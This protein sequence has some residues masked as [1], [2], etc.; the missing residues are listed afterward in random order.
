[1]Y[2]IGLS[3]QTSSLC[4]HGCFWCGSFWC[5]VHC[6]NTAS[7]SPQGFGHS[8]Y[9]TKEA[10]KVVTYCELSKAGGGK[11]SEVGRNGG[12]RLDNATVSFV[13]V[14]KELL[15]SRLKYHL[16]AIWNS[17]Q[18]CGL[19]SG[20]LDTPSCLTISPFSL[21]RCSHFNWPYFQLWQW[22]WRG[23]HQQFGQCWHTE[24]LGGRC[25]WWSHRPPVPLPLPVEGA[26]SVWAAPD[27]LLPR[28]C[29]ICLPRLL[30]CCLWDNK[31]GDKGRKTSEGGFLWRP[32]TN[33]L[34]HCVSQY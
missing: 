11:L 7:F 22:Q 5:V 9:T 23:C 15:W 6:H 20:Q 19:I 32:T 24:L 34:T 12:T 10:I 21:H 13:I 14:W 2:T 17:I 30:L 29:H 8:Q 33:Q 27:G 25:R 26:I 31:G 4:L 3:Q 16:T 1:M 28:V 18:Q